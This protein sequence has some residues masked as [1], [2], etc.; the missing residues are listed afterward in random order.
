MSKIFAIRGSPT[1]QNW[2]DV[3]QLPDYIDFQARDPVSL[4][5]L[6]PMMS[7]NA[8]DLMD[9]MLQ[10]DP[11]RRPSAQEALAHPY[12]TEEPLACAP[13]ELPITNLI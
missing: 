13:S 10:L 3:D 11:N 2:P 1:K 12:F 4:K 6:F 5:T 8:L 9:K 7:D